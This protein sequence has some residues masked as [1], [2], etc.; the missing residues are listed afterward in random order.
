M[1]LKKG[2]LQAK[3]YDEQIQN[4]IKV[5][6]VNENYEPV[7]FRALFSRWSESKY[8][9]NSNSKSLQV[10]FEAHVLN[11][12]IQLAA[13]LQMVDDGSGSKKIWN[14]D[15]NLV[16]SLLDDS[17]HG[18]FHSS[19]CYVI[20]YKYLVDGV[21]RFIIFY[22]IVSFLFLFFFTFF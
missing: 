14:I 20:Q 12:N 3:G 19:N 13:E 10:K 4:A 1:F 16:I 18:Q 15:N 17:K 2:F 9:I 11:A 6:C 7:E 5:T 22:W 21:D 8:S